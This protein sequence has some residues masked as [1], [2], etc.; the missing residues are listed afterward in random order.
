MIWDYSD[1]SVCGRRKA[2]TAKK[3]IDCFVYLKSPEGGR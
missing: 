2:A 1:S 3:P